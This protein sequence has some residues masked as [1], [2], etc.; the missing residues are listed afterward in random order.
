MNI[1]RIEIII[2]Q[3]ILIA[4]IWNNQQAQFFN[5]KKL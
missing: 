1:I 3:L 4:V 5:I 2:I